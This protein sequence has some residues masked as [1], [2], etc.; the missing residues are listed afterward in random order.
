MKYRSLLPALLATLLVTSSAVAD[1]PDATRTALEAAVVREALDAPRVAF[2]FTGQGA[3]YTGMGQSLYRT[4]ST[5]RS[6]F[7]ECDEAGVVRTLP[8]DTVAVPAPAKLVVVAPDSRLQAVDKGGLVHCFE[9]A[10]ARHA[11]R[12]GAEPVPQVE[13]PGDI[14]SLIA[15][16]IMTYEVAVGDGSPLE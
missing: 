6:A 5:F 15:G 8:V 4:H 16:V 13:A 3:Q 2:L 9:Y 12:E 10:V 7:D 14:D 11:A 1:T